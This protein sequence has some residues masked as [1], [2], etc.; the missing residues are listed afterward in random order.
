MV[1]MPGPGMIIGGIMGY[2][3]E[4]VD[5]EGKPE[6]GK[7]TGGATSVLAGTKVN[8]FSSVG[9]SHLILTP[10]GQLLRTNPRDTVFGTTAVNDFTSGPPGA[11]GMASRETN[12]LLKKIIEQNETLINETR[13]S[14]DKIVTGMGAL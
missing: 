8:D 13:R 4:P 5:P 10:K 1:G 14:P 9:G 3:D 2:Y 6:P 12:G 11:M 7:K